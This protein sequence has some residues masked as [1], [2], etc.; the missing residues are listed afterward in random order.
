MRYSNV[1]RTEKCYQQDA[2][3][4]FL[5]HERIHE[6]VNCLISQYIRSLTFIPPHLIV[7]VKNND[8]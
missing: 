6:N 1:Q 7:R 3:F 8:D 2:F 4:S 5:T